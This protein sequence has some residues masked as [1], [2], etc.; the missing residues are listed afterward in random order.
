MVNG[1]RL[2]LRVLSIILVLAT[3]GGLFAVTLGNMIDDNRIIFWIIIFLLIAFYPQLLK[4]MNN[5][6]DPLAIDFLFVCALSLY[7]LTEPIRVVRG[8][9]SFNLVNVEYTMIIQ[10]VA[11]IFFYIGY[12]WSQGGKGNKYGIILTEKHKQA[13]WLIT[14]MG[15]S[16]VLVYL[17]G[18]GA[19]SGLSKSEVSLM[20]SSN[21]WV[22]SFAFGFKFLS[23]GLI[24]LFIIYIKR[25]Y[26]R[27]SLTMFF[28]ILLIYFS[29]SMLI[30]E[31]GEIFMLVLSLIII[32][33]YRVKRISSLLFIPLAFIGYFLFTTM[34]YLKGVPV[35][36]MI[37]YFF[38]NVQWIWYTDLRG[39]FQSAARNLF[40]LVEHVPGNID[41]LYGTTFL[42]AIS[43]FIP[44][45]IWPNR[46]SSAIGW[47]NNTFFPGVRESGGGR[48]FSLIGE[49]YANFGVI[50]VCALFFVLGIVCKFLYNK[51]R[52]TASD[53]WMV[54]YASFIPILIYCIRAD[55]TNMTSQFLKGGVIVFLI[56]YFIGRKISFK[57]S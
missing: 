52:Y 50:G 1:G 17:V 16:M 35:Y 33:H 22:S 18:T 43:N 23:V 48:G 26:K 36:K 31:R 34:N 14:I 13:A 7:S 21:Q 11:L 45:S 10:I 25:K 40:V 49:G 19:F 41:Y 12:Y 27:K 20:K 53:L 3:L 32:S 30:G 6:F 55:V 46:P 42:S 2:D 37:P 56:I 4:I 24:T 29:L 47:F 39:E 9:S 54:A 5:Q 57:W 44:S 28:T 8:L 51:V 38:E 15:I